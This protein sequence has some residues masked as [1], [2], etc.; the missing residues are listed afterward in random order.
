MAA[1]TDKET[2]AAVWNDMVADQVPRAFFGVDG[3]C[4]K[5][6]GNVF[7]AVADPD[8]GYRSSFDYMLPKDPAG[9]IFFRAPIDSVRIEELFERSGLDGWVLRSV[10]DGH[11][12]LRVGT[13]YS[14]GYYP[15]F[16]FQYSPRKP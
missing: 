9:L 3:E 6:D 13:D 14:D 10:L 12:W 4:F 11:V 16:S 15:C 1:P 8:D 2:Y 7:E 5:L